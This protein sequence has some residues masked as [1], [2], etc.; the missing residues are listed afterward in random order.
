MRQKVLSFAEVLTGA[1]RLVPKLLN[2][3]GKP[4]LT[5]VAKY[6]AERGWPVSQPTLHRHFHPDADKPRDLDED[7]AKA[8]EAVFGLRAGLWKGE[9]MNEQE[10][11]ALSQFGFETILLA[12][13]IE[14]L[15]KKDRDR[16]LA[17]IEAATSHHEE[18]RRLMQNTNVTPIDRGKR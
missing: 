1:A 6:C 2:H 17:E 4:V 16:I 14:A 13:K 8:L 9:P 11:K 7:T 5:R 10:A 18:I 3:D 12:Q 15:P